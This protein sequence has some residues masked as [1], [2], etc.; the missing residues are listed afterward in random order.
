MINLNLKHFLRRNDQQGMDKAEVQ[1]NKFLNEIY[2]EKLEYQ[3]TKLIVFLLFS[4]IA[5]HS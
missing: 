4:N 3:G 1:V 2:V 5:V